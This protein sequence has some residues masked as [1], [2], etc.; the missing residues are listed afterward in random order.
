MGHLK[1]WYRYMHLSQV[2]VISVIWSIMTS[3]T[4][5]CQLFNPYKTV[6][7]ELSP[8]RESMIRQPNCFSLYTGFLWKSVQ[9]IKALL[10]VIRSL[11]VLSCSC[12][13]CISMMVSVSTSHLLV[14]GRVR[15]SCCDEIFGLSL[16]MLGNEISTPFSLSFGIPYLSIFIVRVILLLLNVVEEK[17]IQADCFRWYVFGVWSQ[18]DSFPSL[19]F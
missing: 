13:Q 7:R 2:D 14:L 5:V 18:C 6:L 10:S 9:N 1:P 4:M 15:L 16:F 17:S 12:T 8:V 3:P 19:V 11:M